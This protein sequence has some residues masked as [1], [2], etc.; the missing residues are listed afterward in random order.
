M[1]DISTEKSH[2]GKDLNKHFPLWGILFHIANSHF[3][4]FSSFILLL[5]FILKAVG[6]DKVTDPVCSKH[7]FETFFTLFVHFCADCI[8]KGLCVFVL[9]S[10]FACYSEPYLLYVC[11]YHSYYAH[12]ASLRC[13]GT[14]CLIV[15]WEHPEA[16]FAF[17]HGNI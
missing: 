2:V 14:S 7:C 6:V 17:F 15:Q 8:S 1:H 16:V 4:H 13:H 10:V 5:Y 11:F 12:D 3:L 9:L